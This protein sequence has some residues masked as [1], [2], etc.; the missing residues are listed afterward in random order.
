MELKKRVE[1]KKKLSKRK[2]IIIISTI[3]VAIL[4]VIS[5]SM[6]KYK[7]F[8]IEKEREEL[9]L[10]IK[11]AY[12]PYIKIKKDTNLYA[13]GL[14]KVGKINKGIAFEIEQ[15]KE[16]DF[17]Y[18]KIKDTNY[19]IHYKD[20]QKIKMIP[21][22]EEHSHYI[23]L[24]KDVITKPNTKLYLE[25]KV[26]IVLKKSI[27][28]PVKFIDGDFYIQYLN[29]IFHINKKDVKTLK[30][31]ENST[32]EESKYI[33]II[34]YNILANKCNSEDC[35]NIQKFDEQ[36][37]YL[38]TNG[39]YTITLKEYKNWLNGNIRLK[40]KAI[41][42]TTPNETN[43]VLSINNKYHNIL[44][45]V[46]SNEKINFVDDNR[47]TT[48][49]SKLDHLSRYNIKIDTRLGDF[50]R[51]ALGEYVPVVMKTNF[52][53]KGG[54]KI[55]VL[56]YH[57]FYDTNTDYCGENICLDIKNF[58][59]QLEYLKN[60]QY[61]TLTI[62]EYR[63]WMYQEIELPDK[64][65]L[66]TIDDGAFGTGRHNGN[67]LIPILEEYKMHATLFL[68]AGWWDI[69][70]YSSP[71]LDI[72][73]HT[74]DMH[75]TGSCGRAQVI[76]ASH[77]ELLSDLQKSIS[78]IG[79]NTAFCFP[80]YSYDEKSINVVKE[81]GF[82]LS[83][84]GGNRKSS[85]SDNKYKIPRYPIYKHTSMEQFIHMVN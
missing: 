78:V 50:E 46:N 28:V 47:K 3:L 71:N 5:F 79:H 85:R 68:I 38:K 29:K 62:E 67:K 26:V 34:N 35:I 22:G 45:V 12:H 60:N 84:V 65:V 44:N 23:S 36:M 72:E 73:S 81:A 19:Y 40:P 70:N 18:F 27:E 69:N 59:E 48:R 75:N 2:K 83:F 39:Y 13:K 56:N 82:K 7:E 53:N 64:S 21:S 61:K 58:K 57:F 17:E 1:E 8:K 32:E 37:N 16:K 31:N 55:P 66:I 63:S 54:Q 74:Y 24:N 6:I 42:L 9:I 52:P 10:N 33:S 80:F 43:E 20:I 14:V 15:E 30:E 25:N 51:M 49:D 11:K 4:L 76:C 77:D 41:L